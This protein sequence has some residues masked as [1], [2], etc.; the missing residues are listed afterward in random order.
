MSQEVKKPRMFSGI[1]GR[2]ASAI[3]ISVV[4]SEQQSMVKMP[5]V[6]SQPLVQI[7]STEQPS[8]NV[9]TAPSV[10]PEAPHLG[11][12]PTTASPD[13]SSPTPLTIGS[14]APGPDESVGSMMTPA[15]VLPAQPV[16]VPAE[17]PAEDVIA[18]PTPITPEEPIAP[19]IPEVPNFDVAVP[20][21]VTE[22]LPPEPVSEVAAP[23]Q[24]PELSGV[25]AAP[26]EPKV[27]E[28][29][30]EVHIAEP[31]EPV[32][33]PPSQDLAQ[34]EPVS[35]PE[36]PKTEEPEVKVDPIATSL[37]VENPDLIK[38]GVIDMEEYKKARDAK[39][40]AQEQQERA[41]NLIAQLK[42]LGVDPK[43][44]DEN[45]AKWLEKKLAA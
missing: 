29:I 9:M 17:K 11:F 21:P 40:K 1:P 22:V 15:D 35:A 36:Q 13:S 26:A 23:A 37:F 25:E 20:E 28:P 19:I 43:V 10:S 39:V 8:P 27:E 44:I 18:T 32:I 2:V 16:I 33:E 42:N 5:S 4:P 31:A 41:E 30:P 12:V 7:P 24:A 38:D 14:K 3:G 6:E 34:A 45:I